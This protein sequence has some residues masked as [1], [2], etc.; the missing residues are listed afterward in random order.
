MQTLTNG[1]TRI[2]CAMDHDDAGY[3][4]KWGVYRS[5]SGG[6]I[7]Q[8][9]HYLARVRLATTLADA[10]PAAPGGGTAPTPTPTPTATPCSG[11][12]SSGY[13]RLMARHSGKAMTV[14]SASTANSANV[15]QWTYG[16]SNTND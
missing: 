5:G 1:S 11:C 14:Q 3:Y 12:G 9:V 2:P 6:P 4:W 15:F 10:L 13:Y 16:G 8:S 7:G